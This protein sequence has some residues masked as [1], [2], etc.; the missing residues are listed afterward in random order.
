[1]R[2]FALEGGEDL[3]GEIWEMIE[4]TVETAAEE[5]RESEREEEWDLPGLKRRIMLDFF[6]G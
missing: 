5:Y 2:L 6:A 4:H 3:K 1:M